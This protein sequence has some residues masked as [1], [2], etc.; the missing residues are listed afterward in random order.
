M[1]VEGRD[2][3]CTWAKDGDQFRLRVKN[4]PHL[5]G[6]GASF[7]EAQELLR[8]VICLN[9]GDGE[10]VT[11]FSPPAP[12]DPEQQWYR[13]AWLVCV[14]GASRADVT[15]FAPYFVGGLCP[16]CQSPLGP[17]NQTPLAVKRIEGQGNGALA[18]VPL[19]LLR[20]RRS[21][22]ASLFSE[23]FLALLTPEEQSQL[24]WQPIM[25][26]ERRA[27][28]VFYELIGSRVQVGAV[29]GVRGVPKRHK[30]WRC[31]TCDHIQRAMSFFP[32]GPFTWLSTVDLPTPLPSCFT[33]GR[34]ASPQLCFT[35]ARWDSLL[36]NLGTRG[37][38]SA[39]VGVVAPDWVEQLPDPPFLDSLRR[40]P[41]T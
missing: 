10:A 20:G 41:S 40:A 24:T 5:S 21:P 12:P 30:D 29:G 26:T 36:G 33:I 3:L 28:R 2:Y 37:L 9:L 13:R 23:E 18:A 4:R 17:R 22:W 1:R 34:S 16:E 39:P 8:E 25:R 14:S 6:S 15:T 7:G 38:Q 32:Q 27:R 19:H 35:Q 31:R 11:E